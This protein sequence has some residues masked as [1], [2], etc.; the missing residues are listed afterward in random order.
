[1]KTSEK[2]RNYTLEQLFEAEDLA[3]I[4]KSTPEENRKVLVILTKV[5]ISGVKAG[6]ELNKVAG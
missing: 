6:E 2:N 1:M 3:K 4:L 5:F